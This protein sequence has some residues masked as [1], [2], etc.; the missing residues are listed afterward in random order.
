MNGL[1]HLN[2]R[3]RASGRAVEPFPSENASK[4]TFD[5]FMF[6]IG[7]IYPFAYLPQVLEVYTTHQVSAFALST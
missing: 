2:I 7:M 3:R 1:H 6:F 4:R 5:K